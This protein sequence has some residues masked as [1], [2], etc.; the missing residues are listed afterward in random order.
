MQAD[1][2]KRAAARA[3]GGPTPAGGAGLGGGGRWTRITWSAVGEPF[4]ALAYH[5]L[6]SL[7]GS[8]LLVFGGFGADGTTPEGDTSI[9]LS[10]ENDYLREFR[11]GGN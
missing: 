10:P 6:V 5:H 4:P 8:R 9:I 11:S 7:P 3:G 1:G 2:G